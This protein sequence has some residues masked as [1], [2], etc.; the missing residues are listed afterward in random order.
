MTLRAQMVADVDV[1]LNLDEHAEA[2]DVNNVT[3]TVIRES[4][5]DRIPVNQFGGVQY[6]QDITRLY[7]SEADWLA[8]GFPADPVSGRVYTVGARRMQLDTWTLQG[9]M[10]ILDFQT[11]K[12]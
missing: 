5:D 3:L 10:Y 11:A 6:V 4:R 9:G 8:G 12:V 7:V 1:L 2:V